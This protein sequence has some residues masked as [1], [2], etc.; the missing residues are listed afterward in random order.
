M[1]RQGWRQG[2]PALIPVPALGMGGGG[3]GMD[4]LSL[5][6]AWGPFPTSDFGGNHR[7][8][9]GWHIRGWFAVLPLGRLTAVPSWWCADIWESQTRG[10]ISFVTEMK[11]GGRRR[12]SVP[13]IGG[14][15]GLTTLGSPLQAE[16]LV[17]VKKKK[18]RPK[19]CLGLNQTCSNCINPARWATYWCIGR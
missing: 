2:K 14:V 10:Q 18:T 9:H 3:G 6:A 16:A 1:Y 8:E 13:G 17:W 5:A 19:T 7:G 4:I 11:S 15:L 12:G